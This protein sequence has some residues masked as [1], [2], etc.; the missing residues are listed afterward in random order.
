MPSRLSCELP[1]TP[2]CPDQYAISGESHHGAR[3][4]C[5]SDDIRLSASS[6]NSI[7]SCRSSMR[8]AYSDSLGQIFS[9]QSRRI[10]KIDNT[11]ATQTRARDLI[12]S[13]KPGSTIAKIDKKKYAQRACQ[14]VRR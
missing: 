5:V 4:E 13:S 10:G 6:R 12:G 3:N 1:A 11:N 14:I 7:D 8:R 2:G 9:S